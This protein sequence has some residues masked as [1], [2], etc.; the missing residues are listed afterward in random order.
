ML[1][2]TPTTDWGSILGRATIIHFQY[3]PAH[4]DRATDQPTPNWTVNL[5]HFSA[6]RTGTRGQDRISGRWI[7]TL[8]R[9]RL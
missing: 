9:T 5:Y 1:T 8:N 4:F 3:C 2:L 6:M 7:D